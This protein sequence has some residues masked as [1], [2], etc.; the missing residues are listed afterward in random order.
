MVRWLETDHLAT[1]FPGPDA[2][3]VTAAELKEA[4]ERAQQRFGA[5]QSAILHGKST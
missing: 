5:V 4:D 3:I 2:V 1:V